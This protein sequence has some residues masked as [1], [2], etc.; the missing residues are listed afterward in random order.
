MHHYA[1]VTGRVIHLLKHLEP[2]RIPDDGAETPVFF[3]IGEYVAGFIPL[4]YYLASGKISAAIATTGAAT[5]L[6]TCGL[7]DAKL[8]NIPAI[9]LI[10]LSPADT[11]HRAPLQDTSPEGPALWLS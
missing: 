3:N 11:R 8:H 2:M 5:R 7:S 1:G 6:L 9:Y 10:P 4:G